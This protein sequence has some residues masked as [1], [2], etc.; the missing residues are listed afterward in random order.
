MPDERPPAVPAG[1]AAAMTPEQLEIVDWLRRNAPVLAGVFAGAVTFIATT[2]PAY[3]KFV[4]HGVREIRNALPEIL[5]G[6]KEGRFEYINKLDAL[7]Q[8]WDRA[9]LLAPNTFA[10]DEKKPG[11]VAVPFKP[12]RLCAELLTEHRLARERT[13]NAAQ[14][15]FNS[16]APENADVPDTMGP[17][18]DQWVEVTQ[19]FMDRTH[20]E[21]GAVRIVP[22]EELVVKFSLFERT[23]LA[24]I[25][26]FY[27]TIEQLDA[28]L[29][30]ANS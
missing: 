18:I 23:L 14:R 7:Y 22:H 6:V 16:I 4:A 12:F 17:V 21:R 1:S 3:V 19:W 5:S 27:P 13:G 20:V 9:G 8:Q 25:R 29:E 24:M 10:S 11:P 2:P 26:G 15:L 28:I 30:Q